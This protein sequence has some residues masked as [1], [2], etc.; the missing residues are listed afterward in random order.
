MLHVSGR[1]HKFSFL[2]MNARLTLG[3]RSTYWF[4]FRERQMLKIQRSSN[5]QVV[6][7]LSGQIDEEHIAELET[8]IR[9]EANAQSIVLD[10]KDRNSRRSRCRETFWSAAKRTESP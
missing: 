8:Y 4:V 10:L 5:G 3:V 1:L 2:G 6:F 9:A 7:T